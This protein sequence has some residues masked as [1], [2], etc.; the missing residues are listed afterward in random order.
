MKKFI[1]PLLALAVAFA[2]ISAFAADAPAK[3]GTDAQKMDKPVKAKKARKAKKNRTSKSKSG[4][5]AGAAAAK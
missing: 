2:S 5:Q 4:D 1:A 3:E